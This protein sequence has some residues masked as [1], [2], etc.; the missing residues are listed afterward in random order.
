MEESSHIATQHSDMVHDAQLDY[1]GKL[2]ATCSSDRTIKVFDVSTKGQTKHICDITGHEG[3]VWQVPIF[4][5]YL[6]FILLISF[7]CI[8]CFWFCANI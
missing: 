8:F 3:P 2:L 6:L 4:F 7:V 1:Y 5:I